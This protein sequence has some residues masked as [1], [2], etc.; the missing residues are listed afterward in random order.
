MTYIRC[1]MLLLCGCLV[2]S[3]CIH[4]FVR[5]VDSDGDGVIEKYVHY[6]RSRVRKEE[7]DR[8]GDG[9]VDRVVEYNVQG[10]I[11]RTAHDT[12]GD[13][14]LD[15][16]DSYFDDFRV[17]SLR[18]RNKD[19]VPDLGWTTYYTDEG[20]KQYVEYDIDLDGRVDSVF[21]VRRNIRENR[22]GNDWLL[23]VKKG[24]RHGIIHEGAWS[25]IIFEQGEWITVE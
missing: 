15:A 5:E 22:V 12:D 8:N 11:E 23:D 4:R 21:K 25:E 7:I 24:Q 13:S 14:V 10:K 6:E 18:D 20:K 3:G 17:K 16:W 9:H 19:S 2:I 1:G